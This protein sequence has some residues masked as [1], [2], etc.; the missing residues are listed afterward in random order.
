MDRYLRGEAGLDPLDIW[1]SKLVTGRPPAGVHL[2][3]TLDSELQQAAAAG[4]EG[5]AGAVVVV[6]ARSGDIL[7]MASAPSFDPN[8]LEADWEELIGRTDAP[9]LNRAA[10][11]RYQPGMTLAPLLY[12]WGTA[13]GWIEPWLPAPDFSS[14]VRVLD[15]TIG[16][17]RQPQDEA[18]SSWENALALGCAAPFADLG[19]EMGLE[20][21]REALTEFGLLAAPE[22]LL[23]VAPASDTL[24]LGDPGLLAIGQGELTTTPLQLAQAFSVLTGAGVRPELRLVAGVSPTPGEWQALAAL[25]TAEPIL[26]AVEGQHAIDPLTGYGGGLKGYEVNA[27]SGAGSLGWFVGLGPSDEVVVVLL[28]DSRAALAREV[29]LHVL[30]LAIDL[31]LTSRGG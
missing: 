3:L 8:R 12:A 20:A 22:I 23:P 19:E 17:E 1:W 14:P 26:P 29:G 31:D 30:R 13:R 16:C 21:L 25:E 7:A 28:E 5:R 2:R 27:A 11:G 9:L 4:L 10:Q 24:D 15:R 6:D 18:A